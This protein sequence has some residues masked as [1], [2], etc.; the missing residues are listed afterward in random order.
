MGIKDQGKKFGEWR[1]K[2][3]E[4]K[5]GREKWSK[6][7][8]EENKK[9]EKEENERQIEKKKIINPCTGAPPALQG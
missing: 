3:I 2:N 1:Q 9:K 6:E 5:K 8:E 4:L 7:N